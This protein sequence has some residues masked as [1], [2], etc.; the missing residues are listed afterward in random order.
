MRDQIETT[1][2]RAQQIFE[3]V[4][5]RNPIQ[6]EIKDD[7]VVNILKKHKNVLYKSTPLG[8][9]SQASIKNNTKQVFNTC[10]ELI[11]NFKINVFKQQTEY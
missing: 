6:I 10:R 7:R 3:I 9:L 1:I 11:L 8:I 5:G 2:I 4:G